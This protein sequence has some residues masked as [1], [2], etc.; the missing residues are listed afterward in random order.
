MTES[1]EKEPEFTF[2][3]SARNLFPLLSINVGGWHVAVNPKDNESDE[4]TAD[5]VINQIRE[6]IIKELKEIREKKEAI[7]KIILP[8]GGVAKMLR[9]FLHP[10]EK[11]S[12]TEMPCGEG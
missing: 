10:D 7:P 1:D 11:D 4:Q 2:E 3:E 12:S 8:N 9:D 6:L 5:R